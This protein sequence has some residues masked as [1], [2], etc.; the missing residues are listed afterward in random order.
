MLFK[1]F[2]R[3]N[4]KT[5]QRNY[6]SV[7]EELYKRVLRDLEE[8]KYCEVSA[9]EKEFITNL[10]Y[11]LNQ[12]NEFKAL[13]LRRMS[14]KAIDVSYNMYPIGKIKLLGKKTWMQVFRNLYDVE[15]I[16]GNLEVYINSIDLWIKYIKKYL[17]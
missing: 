6:P 17:K 2:N 8:S 11:K 4:N 1:L 5:S 14:S 7:N 12:Q 9:A 13:K 3:K 16:E 10:M 15:L